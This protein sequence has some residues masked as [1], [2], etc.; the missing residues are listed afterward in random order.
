M[1]LAVLITKLL[2]PTTNAYQEKPF[3]H[4]LK[5][6]Q[7]MI[8]KILLS[9]LI[10]SASLPIHAQMLFSENLTMDIDS[11]KTIQGTLLPVLD[12]KILLSGKPFPHN[13]S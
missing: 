13:K 4:S 8:K 10:V 1:F 7:I 9:L 3:F 11:T 12:F 5:K 2:K 6:H